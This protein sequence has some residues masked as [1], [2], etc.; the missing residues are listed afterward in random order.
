LLNFIALIPIKQN[1]GYG[2]ALPIV[3][4]ILV[5][6]KLNVAR[7]F[8]FQRNASFVET[9]ILAQLLRAGFFLIKRAFRPYAFRHIITYFSP[10]T[11]L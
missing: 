5:S 2:T 9:F 8:H 4:A 3:I 7:A 6:I 1:P 11:I 10:R